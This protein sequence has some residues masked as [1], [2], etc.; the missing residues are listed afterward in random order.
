MPTCDPWDR[1]R[2]DFGE[3]HHAREARCDRAIVST[4]FIITPLGF[5]LTL[6]VG[7]HATITRWPVDGW[8]AIGWSVFALQFGF[9]FGAG[10]ALGIARLIEWRYA[11]LD[12]FRCRLCGDIFQRRVF[13]CPCFEQSEE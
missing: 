11:R 7:I 4:V 3:E 10:A 8:T 12:T 5:L 13:S 6:A 2:L 1:R 9:I